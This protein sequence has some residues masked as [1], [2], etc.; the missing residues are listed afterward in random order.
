MD[1]IGLIWCVGLP[2]NET[3]LFS[4]PTA[5]DDCTLGFPASLSE[6]AKGFRKLDKYSRSGIGVCCS[7]YDPG[8]SVVAHDDYFVFYC[9][10]CERSREE[11]SVCLT[12]I[13]YMYT[14]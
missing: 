5:Q 9:S 7:S 1:Q 3:V 13:S 8:V 2:S 11:V 14:Y 10:V 12:C 4:I 6:S